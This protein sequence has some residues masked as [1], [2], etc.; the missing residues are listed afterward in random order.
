MKALPNNPLNIAAASL[1]GLGGSLIY[2]P[3]LML[4]A[5]V[6]MKNSKIAAAVL[7]PKRVVTWLPLTWGN[8]VAW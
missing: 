8:I 5:N 7:Q 3:A 6:F 4:V 2:Y 1:V